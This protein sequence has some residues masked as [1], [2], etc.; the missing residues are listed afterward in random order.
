MIGSLWMTQKELDLLST[1]FGFKRVFICRKDL[2]KWETQHVVRAVEVNSEKKDD[3]ESD[4]DDDEEPEEDYFVST[5][6]NDNEENERGNNPDDSEDN[7][8]DLSKKEDND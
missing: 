4:L 1:I 3:D 7:P 2:F 8:L 6:S 5:K